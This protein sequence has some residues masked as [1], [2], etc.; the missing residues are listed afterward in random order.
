MDNFDNEIFSFDDITNIVFFSSGDFGIPTFK[1]LIENK[2]YNVKGVV[3]SNDKVVYD[4]KRIVDIADANGIPCCIPSNDDE[5]YHFLKDIKDDESEFG[6][7]LYY[8]VI[9]YKKLSDRILSLVDG[10]AMN[11]HASILP[12]LRGA[13]PINWAIRL[14][15][16]ETGLT[17]FKLSDKI[18]R[19]DIINSILVNIN[20]D[21]TYDSL[22]KKLSDKC[23]DFTMG[24]LNLFRLMSITSQRIGRQPNIGVKRDIL[25]APKITKKYWD[26]WLRLSMKE[27]D[28]LFK[29]TSNGLPCKI[30]VI[31]DNKNTQCDA[32]NAKIW[33]YEFISNFEDGS[34]GV[35]W[36]PT[37]C[38]GKTYIRVAFGDQVEKVMT[39]KEIQ[40][41]GR[42]R[43]YIKD[44]LRG[45]KYTRNN[46]DNYRLVISSDISE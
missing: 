40:L 29:S 23:V 19:G 31:D 16:K 14:G 22:F 30:Y 43:M 1:A 3:T 17:A 26:G 20:D 4:D 21:E 13:A 45:F 38:D 42:K 37:E 5:L 12:F 15:F 24:S 7:N 9:S 35:N 36:Y 6:N 41:E 25:V 28:R 11:V 32:L 33:D 34:E 27:I 18:D 44:F 46:K 10:R 39:I 2:K 8:C